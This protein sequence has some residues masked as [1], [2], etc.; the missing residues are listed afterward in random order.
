MGILVFGDIQKMLNKFSEMKHCF[1]LIFA[2]MGIVSGQIVNGPN[3]CYSVEQLPGHGGTAITGPNGT[4]FITPC[5][6]GTVVTGSGNI[7]G[8]LNA[9]TLVRAATPPTQS[10]PI[11]PQTPQTPICISVPAPIVVNSGSHEEKPLP[12]PKNREAWIAWCKANHIPNKSL[13]VK[14]YNTLVR[15]FEIIQKNVAK[16]VTPIP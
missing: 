12:K 6:G 8:A 13:P 4:T 15:A 5:Y 9:A 11:I 16:N 2:S 14:E 7:Q 1:V 10:A 3:G